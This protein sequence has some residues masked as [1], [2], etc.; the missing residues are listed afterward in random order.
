MYDRMW[1][2]VFV[3]MMREGNERDFENRSTER[4]IE[5][6]FFLSESELVRSIH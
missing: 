2:I 6:A 5:S 4:S 3:P 1:T